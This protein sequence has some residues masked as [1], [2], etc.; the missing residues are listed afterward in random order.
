MSDQGLPHVPDAQRAKARQYLAL[1][2]LA[3]LAAL[4]IV[5]LFTPSGSS[6]S[7]PTKQEGE[8]T[9]VRKI[10][11]P[12]PVDPQ[13]AWVA[14]GERQIEEL[15]KERSELMGALDKMRKE[16][17]TLRARLEAT[18]KA[19]KA[20]RPAR[21]ALDTGTT[22]P[23]AAASTEAS[24]ASDGAGQ[25][26]PPLPLLPPRPEPSPEPVA[27]N[28]PATLPR[29]PGDLLPPPPR[30][31]SRTSTR[32]Q[33]GGQPSGED[34]ILELV[35]DDPHETASDS[36]NDEPPRTIDDY[37]PAGSF[38][39]VI[40]LSGLDAPTGGRNQRDPVPFLVRLKDHG[41]L[42]N[43]FRSRLK[44][45]VAVMA[46]RGDISS[47]RVYARAERLSC[48]L[49]DGRVIETQIDGYLAGEDGKAGMRGRLVSKQGALIARSLLA[50]VAGGIGSGISESYSSL[51]TNALGTVQTVDPDKIAEQGIAEGFGSALDRIS[52]WYLERADEA[53]PVIEVDAGRYAEL[54]LVKGV[55]VSWE[56]VRQAR[57]DRAPDAPPEPPRPKYPWKK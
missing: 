40:L 56:T 53:Y 25:S 36:E 50:G 16:M 8:K 30:S 13:Q 6:G 19:Q 20:S 46:G 14:K 17:E 38:G 15:R 52:Q 34:E 39:R 21:P 1:A 22:K 7:R 35:I 55:F 54:V 57:I 32:R 29:P 49:E 11:P 10:Q 3:L 45:C 24:G 43:G 33:T 2:G 27:S 4:G 28:E 31:G 47:E 51:S 12:A 9:I 44:E 26:E 48:V 41:R 5:W 23:A 18:E 42:P 37:V